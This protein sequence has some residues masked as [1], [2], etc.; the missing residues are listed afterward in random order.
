MN[1]DEHVNALRLNTHTHT[2]NYQPAEIMQGRA[3]AA[4]AAELLL[5]E[6]AQLGL[7]SSPLLPLGSCG[8]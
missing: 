2:H 7:F 6:G 8:P 3:E 5:G 4:A 1:N